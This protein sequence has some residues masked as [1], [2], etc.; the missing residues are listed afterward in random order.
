MKK[1]ERKKKKITIRCRRCFMTDSYEIEENDKKKE[2]KCK[3][4]G[5]KIYLIDE[6]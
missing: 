3:H 2:Y 5:E 1:M 4:C 6:I